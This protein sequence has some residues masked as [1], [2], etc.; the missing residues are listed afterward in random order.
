MKRVNVKRLC[1]MG[2]LIA[3][4]MLFSYV[5]SLVPVFLPIPGVR[6]GLANIVVLLA[7]LMFKPGEAFLIG[8]IRVLLSGIL[9]GN[10]FSLAMSCSGFLLSFLVMYI[11]KRSDK[12]S[13]PGISIAGGMFHNVA[14]LLC[15][16]IIL[17]SYGIMI[18]MF[19]LCVVGCITGCINGFIC[20]MIF[21]R[22]D[23]HDWISEG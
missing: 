3:A 21:E 14:Q 12:F 23:K 15:A 7:L 8:F 2:V 18:Y 9:F 4:A 17:S 11:F 20:K 1:V 22:T 6:L 16:R 13:I 19:P 5:E 10:P